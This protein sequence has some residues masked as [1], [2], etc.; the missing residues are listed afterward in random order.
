[1][2]LERNPAFK[3][4]AKTIYT[5]PMH[6]EV[7]QDHA[8]NCPICGMALEAVALT[9]DAGE[10]ANEASHMSRRFWISVLLSLP[11]FLLAMGHVTPGFHMDEWI[12]AR[13]NQW[14]QFIFTTPIVMWAGW[15]FFVRAWTSIRTWHLNMFTLIALGVGTAYGFSVVALLF[16]EAFPPDFRMQGVVP[17]YFE[18]AAIIST[19]VLLGQ[20]LEAKARSRTG[21][22][23]KALLNQAAKTARVVRDGEEIEVPISE[24]MKGGILR[25][26]PGEKIPVDGVILEGRSS[27]DE[28][29][30][31]GEP[32]PV[33]K[34][35]GDKLTGATL[36]QTG[37]FLMRA[38]RVGK[39]T[40]LGQI[41]QMVA[42]AQRSRAPIQRLADRVSAW[43]VPAVVLVALVTFAVWGI[44]GPDPKLA[45]ALVNAVAVLI[46]ACPCAL[47]LATPMSIMVGVGRGAREGIL[48][49][50]AETLETLEKVDTVVLDKT[51]TLTEG[52]PR[53]TKVLPA[54]GF[55]EN[56][57]LQIV[58]TLERRSE[59]PLAAAIVKGAQER[60]LS[61]PEPEQFDSVTG[62]GV[63]GR[64]Q[65]HEV[66][67]GNSRLLEKKGIPGLE[68]LKREAE[69][70]QSDGNTIIFAAIDAKALGIL[71][72]ADPIKEGSTDAIAELHQLGLK[73]VML[74][75][76]DKNTAL[77]VARGLKID[78]V[79]AGVAPRDKHDEVR[80]FR[81]SG[82]FVA[83][84]GDGIND[85]AAL[86]AANV[87]IAMGTGTDVAI[88][89][90]GIT[91]VKGDLRGIVKAFRLSRAVMRNIRQNLFFA[92]IYNLLGVPIAAGAL[93]PSFGI[94]LSPIIASAAMSF[95]SV[96]VIANALRL[97][98]AK[99]Q[100]QR[101]YWKEG[102]ALHLRCV[103]DRVVHQESTGQPIA[104]NSI[105]LNS[106]AAD[107]KDPNAKNRLLMTLL[108]GLII[109]GYS[110]ANF[111]Q[112]GA[113]GAPARPAPGKAPPIP[114]AGILAQPRPT[115][116]VGLPAQLS[117]AVVPPDNPLT[118]EKIELGEK[119]FFDGRMSAD[120]TVACATCHDPARAFTDGRPVSIG[121]K[122]RVGQRNAPTIL[123]ALYNKAQFWDG[124]ATNLEDQAMLPIVNSVEM[125]QSSLDAA[126]T[127]LAS[128]EEYRRT[129]LKVFDRPING[130]DLLRALAAYERTLVSFDSPF[131]HFTAG[132]QNA[133]D[134]HAKRGWELFNTKG[135]C[136]KCHALTDTQRDVTNFM[137]N[138]FHNIGIGIIRHKVVPLAHQA[139][140]EI[141]SGN[142]VAVD[143]AAI[144][145]EMSVLGRFLITKK[146]ADT[147]SFKTPNLRNVLVTG[148]YFHDG[149]QMT[150]WDVM[151]HYN[152]GAGLQ[153]PWLDEDIQP[154]ALTEREI[155]DLVAFLASLTSPAYKELGAQEL[156]RQRAISKT[157][158]PQRDTKRAFGPKPPR[159]KPTQQ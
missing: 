88:E 15:P 131:D 69:Q 80:R 146:P 46:I 152:K 120:G 96:S 58:A 61:L 136:N 13:L 142:A 85:A 56:E 106:Q 49:K 57:L 30:L 41:V 135:R 91:L 38:E 63:I 84:A 68:S 66:T 156:E 26:R 75:G 78:D 134:D 130:S 10:E 3:P 98:T 79:R 11:V 14:L 127:N 4:E 32:V 133:I 42:D 17:L 155:D 118:R 128:I 77:A 125:G 113:A 132:D 99:L 5:C 123:N 108:L 53:L 45:H 141:A 39:E 138:D 64:V 110:P 83:M 147:A 102:Q 18:A 122:G 22:A 93:Y 86:A 104:N 73:V 1:M 72:V 139:E 81:E 21:S 90:A 151:D 158:R 97:R 12:P 103:V 89:S 140:Q 115:S 40:M 7:R 2:A 24:V 112:E 50:S 145:S 33:E 23:I 159:P 9:T 70:L 143:R 76:D 55:Q 29:M 95:S 35:P 54:P 137:D 121:I 47:G 153:N 109:F 65:D 8:G 154:L 117:Q 157:S 60:N 82:H 34:G 16:P 149:S 94:L 44:F 51:G 62:G 71:A 48:V 100:T 124:R 19:L 20:M 119:L 126:V 116:Q 37:S 150:L 111:A 107:S 25:V 144:E 92:F 105:P 148:P 67:A 6:P 74:T 27:V 31:T 129:F 36:N 114:K 43:F 59:H 52:K 28:S 101:R 87:G